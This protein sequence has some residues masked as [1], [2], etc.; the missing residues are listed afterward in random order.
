LY[1][2]V[3][4]HDATHLLVARLAIVSERGL[5]GAIKH[6]ACETPSKRSQSIC[7]ESQSDER[8]FM[9]RARGGERRCRRDGTGHAGSPVISSSIAMNSAVGSRA[10]IST[11]ADSK[12]PRVTSIFRAVPGRRD[13]RLTRHRGR[14]EW[15]RCELL[16]SVRSHL[17][18]L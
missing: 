9:K 5:R 2:V 16:N 15:T 10:S 14:R 12:F 17:T 1:E 3:L 13:P 7:S 11:R 6:D 4:A 8:I 18:L